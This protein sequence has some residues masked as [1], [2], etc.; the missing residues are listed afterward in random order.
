MK[1]SLK[2]GREMAMKTTNQALIGAFVLFF[3]C[4]F[5]LHAE[6]K[7]KASIEQLTKGKQIEYGVGRLNQELQ[8]QGAAVNQKFIVGLKSEEAIKKHLT[9][10]ES[11]CKELQTPEGFLV[12]FIGQGQVL[13]VGT[14]APGTMY[15]CLDIAELLRIKGL[16]G[17]PES[18]TSA[19]MLE[20]RGYQFNFPTYVRGCTWDDN[21]DAAHR[22]A[23]WFYD[24]EQVIPF[25]DKLADAKMNTIVIEAT[26]PFAAMVPI[27]GYPEAVKGVE[28]KEPLTIEKLRSERIPYLRW[29]FS[30][31]RR[32]GILPY[33]WFFN[34]FIPD[35]VAE[36]RNI[37]IGEYWKIYPVPGVEKYNRAAIKAFSDTYGDL[38][39]LYIIAAEH[40]PHSGLEDDFKLQNK[41]VRDVIMNSLLESSNRPP[42]ILLTMGSVNDKESYEAI[43]KS[44]PQLKYLTV[45]D[46]DGEGTTLPDV[47]GA[48]ALNF[49]KPFEGVGGVKGTVVLSNLG[50]WGSGNIV[51]YPW[52]SSD[53]LQR[54]G[55]HLI[56]IGFI[57]STSQPMREAFYPDYYE[58]DWLWIRGLGKFLWDSSNLHAEYFNDLVKDRYGCSAEDAVAILQAYEKASQIPTLCKTQFFYGVCSGKYQFGA[59]LMN[60]IWNGIHLGAPGMLSVDGRD[61]HRVPLEWVKTYNKA[62]GI[63]M[64]VD[65][66]SYV[67]DN[68]EAEITPDKLVEILADAAEAC[69]ENI[70]K[71]S[72]ISRRKGEFE[73]LKLNIQAYHFMGMHFS[74]KIKALLDMLRFIRNGDETLYSSGKAHLEKSLEYFLEQREVSKK[75]YPNPDEDLL[76]MSPG[77]ILRHDWDS[78]LPILRDEINNYDKYLVKIAMHLAAD[79]ENTRGPT[80]AWRDYYRRVTEGT[81]E[82]WQPWMPEDP[83]DY[84]LTSP[85]KWDGMG[86]DIRKNEIDHNSDYV[87]FNPVE[88]D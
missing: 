33:V 62:V 70:N 4:T 12:K 64:M 67:K 66:V 5:A 10:V 25:L 48:E 77:R 1:N 68:K 69:L 84:W 43:L 32:R 22:L 51:P 65:I 40:L 41:W 88:D 37:D 17:L 71:V 18:Y 14:D 74:E 38:I 44:Y 54:M 23:P 20:L 45:G 50:G 85:M 35:I 49:Y 79:R 81:V 56:N 76:I 21:R 47:A 9:E 27:P 29:F 73:E 72:S 28:E 13:I 82:V 75:V 30:E 87:P 86:D 6:G 55:Q 53:F 31:C 83:N 16:D 7:A 2:K 11:S 26:H 19:P 36:T 46:H 61:N 80:F 78:I 3:G 34:A 42:C 60:G 52:F 59:P 15:G 58:R 57:G 39:G 24:K 8:R 63:G